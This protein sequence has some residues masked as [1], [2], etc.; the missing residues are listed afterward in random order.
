MSVLDVAYA[1]EQQVGS[2]S[3]LSYATPNQHSALGILML[4]LHLQDAYLN[5]SIISIFELFFLIVSNMI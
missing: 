1:L 4:D 3:R 2:G 5:R